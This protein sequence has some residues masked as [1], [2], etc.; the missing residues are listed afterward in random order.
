MNGLCENGTG[1]PLT[2]SL[3][4]KERLGLL[5]EGTTCS[6]VDFMQAFVVQ[7]GHPS[8]LLFQCH[9]T[10][11]LEVSQTRVACTNPTELD[12]VIHREN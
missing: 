5:I 12:F 8:G 10:F 11:S 3:F 6:I 2:H 7:D 4:P 1:K 9:E